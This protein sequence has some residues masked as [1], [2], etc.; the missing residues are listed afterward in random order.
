MTA[1][2][3]RLAAVVSD[4]AGPLPVVVAL[5]LAGDRDGR[6]WLA[7]VGW[8][9]LAVVLLAVIPYVVTLR[10]RHPADGTRPARARKGAYMALVAALS[11]GGLLVLAL[12]PSPGSVVDVA[13]AVVI[14]LL[15]VA[16]A[17]AVA[18]W[19][20]HTAACAGGAAMCVVL[21]GPA[22]ITLALAVVAVA[23]ARLT[24]GRHSPAQVVL[25]AIWGAAVAAAALALL[26]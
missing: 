12:L 7:S 11:L 6:S 23:W 3:S 19:S 15:A 22:W 24:L 10:L 2:R 13:V 25:G 26:L 8:A 21:A 16:A 17:T 20:N 5:F 4:L 18:A 9:V 14:S 1:E